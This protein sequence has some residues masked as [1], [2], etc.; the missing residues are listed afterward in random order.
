MS[1]Q[2]HLQRIYAA[3]GARTE[4]MA[5]MDDRHATASG[6]S[7]QTLDKPPRHSAHE[8]GTR[9][10]TG[11]HTA[12]EPAKQSTRATP[13]L[14]R[15]HLD[16]TRSE[17]DARGP[18]T[19]AEQAAAQDLELWINGITAGKRLALRV[20]IRRLCQELRHLEDGTRTMAAVVFG[21]KAAPHTPLTTMD[22]PSQWHYVG[23]R[24]MAHMGTYSPDKIT[25]L[26]WRLHQRA[27]LR[28]RAAM[29]GHNI[30]TTLG[31]PGSQGHASGHRRP[32]CQEVPE[33]PRQ[34]T[35]HDS[36]RPHEVSPPSVRSPSGTNG[37]P[38]RPLAPPWDRGSPPA[39]RMKGRAPVSRTP[40]RHQEARNPDRSRRRSCKSPS[41][42]R[43][44][45][46][47]EG[48][49]GGLCRP[50]RPAGPTDIT[51]GRSP[52]PVQ[53]APHR[54]DAHPHHSHAGRASATGSAPYVPRPGNRRCVQL[55]RC[56][57]PSVT[58]RSAAGG[59]EHRGRAAK[60]TRSRPATRTGRGG[61]NP[62]KPTPHAGR[63][64]T[65]PGHRHRPPDQPGVCATGLPTLALRQQSHRGTVDA[66]QRQGHDD[67]GGDEEMTEA[68][69]PQE[70]TSASHLM[71]P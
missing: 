6:A 60:G 8:S 36:T 4:H 23:T 28:V 41:A 40:D 66:P 70:S 58:G 5:A 48:A 25:G 47:H 18:N 35:G 26:H 20:S 68:S 46:F 7:D 17:G 57:P 29:Q 21:H 61:T 9:V 34:M 62:S 27:A 63:N 10:K 51:Y 59:T 31:T 71:A 43:P 69:G 13:A 37:S 32:Q 42:A 44:V 53:E 12:S 16:Y 33:P 2:A 55:V 49:D 50:Q 67:P 15:G 65:S 1:R 38:F 45:V 14:G 54:A 24:L 56:L 52:A 11:T 39:P 22:H 19:D 3:L 30:C 64:S